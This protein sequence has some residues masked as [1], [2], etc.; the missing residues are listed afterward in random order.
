MIR[1][2][3]LGS[4]GSIGQSAL[5]VIARHPER[6]QVV[7]LS[8]HSRVEA[9]SSQVEKFSPKLAVLADESVPLPANSSSTRWQSGRQALIAA[10]ADPEVDVVLNALVG[11]AGLEP[12]LAALQA[13]HRLA[14]ANKESLV[15]GGPLVLRAAE[16]GGGEIVPIDS[17]HSAILQC[18]AGS[19]A[20]EV[21]KLVLTASGGP[22]RGRNPEDLWHVR[23]ED[24]LRHP[25]WNMGAKITIDSATLANKALEIIEAHYLYGLAYDRIE[26]VLHPQSII[27][28]FVEF[29]DGSVLS[30]LG[31]PTME[32]PILYALSYPERVEDDAL[33]TYDPVRSSPLTFEQIEQAAFPLFGLGVE[34]GAKGGAVPAAYNAGNE[35]AVHAFLEGRI[36]FPEM[37]DVVCGAI[38][39]VG[40]GQLTSVEDVLAVDGTARA[41]AT[42]VV[43]RLGEARMGTIS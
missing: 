21:Q 3:I 34:A 1:V 20:D 28:S 42:E 24:A 12:T 43:H 2:A 19:K 23:P 36:R 25:T 8:A 18:L 26:A 40:V 15:A 10:A 35:I 39:G 6:F 32:L 37:A 30:Q 31:L 29:V 11:A 14:L 4:T 5:Q 22:F 16:L 13:G 7:T 17:E 41:V 38:E 27:H 9:L 33:R